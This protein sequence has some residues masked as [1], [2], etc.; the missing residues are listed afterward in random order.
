MLDLMNGL[1]TQDTVDLAIIVGHFFHRIHLSGIEQLSDT[2]GVIHRLVLQRRKAV[3][4]H[5]IRHVQVIVLKLCSAHI[6][7]QQLQIRLPLLIP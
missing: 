1:Q 4:E 2:T 5:S 6:V 7:I 3:V